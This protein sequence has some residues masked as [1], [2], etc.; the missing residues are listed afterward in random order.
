MNSREIQVLSTMSA[1][2][3]MIQ[4]LIYTPLPTAQPAGRMRAPHSGIGSKRLEFDGHSCPR[5]VCR[6]AVGDE[7]LSYSTEDGDYRSHELV[8]AAIISGRATASTPVAC[9]QYQVC[10]FRIVS[11]MKRSTR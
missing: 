2:R 11:A 4:Q 5:L 10:T 6:P 9:G 3:L 8:S 1:G 7:D